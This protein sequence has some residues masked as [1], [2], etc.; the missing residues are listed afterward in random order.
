MVQF[1]PFLSLEWSDCFKILAPCLFLKVK[2]I[3]S[4]ESTILDH[5]FNFKCVWTFSN[6][7]NLAKWPILVIETENFRSK[8][9]FE[10]EEHL[11]YWIKFFL[12]TSLLSNASKRG[13]IW[14]KGHHKG[15]FWMWNDSRLF[16]ELDQGPPCLELPTYP[17]QLLFRSEFCI[18]KNRIPLIFLKTYKKLSFFSEWRLQFL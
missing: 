11:E 3:L 10:S 7:S 15:Q 6:A 2:A 4:I 5:F 18:E 17:F 1:L 8:P 12:T 13:Q 14:P 9:I 16:R